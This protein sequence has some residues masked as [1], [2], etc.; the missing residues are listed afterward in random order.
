M[1]YKIVP[2]SV[3]KKQVKRLQKEY[4]HIKEDLRQLGIFLKA[5]PKNGKPLGKKTYKIRLNSSD[6]KKGK[7]GG[8]RIITFVND[9]T[10]KVYLLTI[11]AK[12]KQTNIT[13][14]EIKEIL[15]Q[16]GLI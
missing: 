5:N 10:K 16:E 4:K 9:E 7:R 2:T 8:F 12:S 14:Q 1:P 11:Y 13:D 6:M 15:K 3:F